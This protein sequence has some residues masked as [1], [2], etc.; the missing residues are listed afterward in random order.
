MLCL[1]P[2]FFRSSVRVLGS[3]AFA[4][5]SQYHLALLYRLDTFPQMYQLWKQTYYIMEN[6]CRVCSIL[7][8]SV[9]QKL[10][11]DT[12][13]VVNEFPCGYLGVLRLC[14]ASHL[15]LPAK[16]LDEAGWCGSWIVFLL[17]S[18]AARCSE[19]SAEQKLILSSCCPW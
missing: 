12:W 6:A 10:F 5:L 17:L 19:L 8:Q 1:F 18:L 14:P 9:E 11:P 13:L 7:N 2:R 15:F 3:Q 16:S 4:V